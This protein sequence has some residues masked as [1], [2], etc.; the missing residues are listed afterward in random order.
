VSPES[1]YYISHVVA[2]AWAAFGWG[3]A[4][5]PGVADQDYPASNVPITPPEAYGSRNGDETLLML[6]EGIERFM[7]SDIN[8]AA[9]SAMAQS[10]IPVMYDYPSANVAQYAHVPGGGNVMYMD[11]HVEFLKYPSIYPFTPKAAGVFSP[12]S[13][14]IAITPGNYATELPPN[15]RSNDQ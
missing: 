4:W 9:A 8:N 7:I 5:N 14:D 1:Y 2:D 12:P 6:R 13:S 3:S 11:G 15:E 10:E